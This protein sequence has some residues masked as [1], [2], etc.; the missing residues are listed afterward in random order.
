[1]TRNFSKLS[2]GQQQAILLSIMLFSKANVPLIIDQPEDN[3]DSEFIYKTFVKT[4]R[5]VKEKRQVVIGTHNANIA[6]LGDAELLIPLR[7]SNEQTVI[8][9]RGSID[10]PATKSTACTILEGSERAFKK[11]K[12][13][14]GF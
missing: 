10:T 12:Q 1:V 8:S 4:V 3:L 5:V 7:A 2:L 11:R 9:T 13:A 14:Y 6:V